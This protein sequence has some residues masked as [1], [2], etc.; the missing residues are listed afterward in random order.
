MAPML[1]TPSIRVLVATLAVV[2]VVVLAVV[3]VSLL[4]ASTG[5]ISERLGESLVD[6]ATSSVRA[7]V[8][9]FLGGAVR[10]SDLYERRL[11]AELLPM[12]DLGAWERPELDDLVVNPGVASICFGAANGETTWLLRRADHLELGCVGPDGSATEFRIDPASGAIDPR[13]LRTYEYDPRKRPWYSMATATGA[14]TWTPVYFWFGDVGAASETGAGYT[15][16]IRRPDG[17]TAGVLVIDVTL[18]GLST[19]LRSL[20][21]SSSGSIYIVDGENRLVAASHGDVNSARGERL[22]L[23][24]SDEPGA[25]ELAAALGDPGH[26]QGAERTVR[27]EV[28]RKAV[29][30]RITPLR[31]YPGID[32]SIVAVIPESAFLADAQALQ[33][34][35]L[36]LSIVGV[37]GSLALAFVLASRIS[38]P[39]VSIAHHVRNVGRGDFHSRLHLR[40]ARELCTLSDELNRMAVALQEHMQLQQSLAVAMQV[41]QDLLPAGPP[42]VAGVDIAGQSKYCDS[43]G[44][45]YY[46]FIE[47]SDLP[48]GRV[49]VAVGDVMG[50]GIAAALLMATARAALRAHAWR[51]GSLGELMDRVNAVLAREARHGRFMTMVLVIVDPLECTVRWASAGHDPPII[52]DARESRFL[53]L[54]GGDLPL[55]VMEDT[56]YEEYV[57]TGLPP[58]SI[59]FIGTDGIW[60]AVNESGAFF[61][62]DKLRD[63]IRKAAADGSTSAVIVDRVQSSLA[64]F[65]GAC[66]P[67][68]D[69]TLVVMRLETITLGSRSEDTAERGTRAGAMTS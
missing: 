63:L 59:V 30:A 40:G 58:G 47:V 13:P 60:E 43:T 41:Q 1:R 28:D 54:E 44:G 32:W 53:D 3:L 29:R 33:R 20:Q 16:P 23:A 48:G 34:R 21:F 37:V 68:D 56:C 11:A 67:Q 26:D 49:L 42:K 4:A 9:T 39:L 62:K 61:G 35:A 10:V 25:R 51:H 38:R 14:P 55:G 24:Q 22:K 6:N 36:L 45:D 64:G 5:E 57:L 52:F 18:S 7:D 17:S 15:R 69:I 46:D 19:F 65:S 8:S 31:P 66:P 2:P 27:F 50:H 12:N